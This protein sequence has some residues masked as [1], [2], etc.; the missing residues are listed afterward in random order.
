MG[1]EIIFIKYRLVLLMVQL[2]NHSECSSVTP[3]LIIYTFCTLMAC[4]LGGWDDR[5]YKIY[6]LN[7]YPIEIKYN[8]SMLGDGPQ[9]I[10]AQF[11][12]EYRRARWRIPRRDALV[13]HACQAA[14]R[15]F[16]LHSR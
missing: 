14:R 5:G 6:E 15:I 13:A 2:C 1:I 3:L 9:S 8:I 16:R 11:S 4:N 7:C 10:A 12:L